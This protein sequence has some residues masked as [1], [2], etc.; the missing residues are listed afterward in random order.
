MQRSEASANTGGVRPKRE[1]NGQDDRQSAPDQQEATR[2]GKAGAEPAQSADA[3]Q[4]EREGASLCHLRPQGHAERFAEDGPA[5]ATLEK[6]VA[7]SIRVQPS[8][9]SGEL[10]FTPTSCAPD[11]RSIIQG[12]L[13]C[14]QTIRQGGT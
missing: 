2:T 11:N 4:R 3:I 6:Q 9:A 10:S 7:D 5:V 12:T 8:R 13:K 14:N 1:A